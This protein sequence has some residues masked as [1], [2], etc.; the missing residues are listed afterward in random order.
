MIKITKNVP[1]LSNVDNPKNKNW[2]DHQASR[3]NRLVQEAQEHYKDLTFGDEWKVV[4]I[5]CKGLILVL[6]LAS[7]ASLLVCF[8]SLLSVRLSYP[9]AFGVSL[10]LCF[11]VEFLKGF[12]WGKLSKNVLKYKKYPLAIL[13]VSCF[14]VAVSVGGSIA[15]VDVLTSKASESAKG[16][17]L[18]PV[19][20]IDVKAMRASNAAQLAEL[21]KLIVDHAEQIKA[22]KSNTT[23]RSLSNG[24][25]QF[26]ASRLK[27]EEINAAAIKQA[28]EENDK[29][30]AE[31][32]AQIKEATKDQQQK[33]DTTNFYSRLLIILFELGLILANAFKSYYLFRVYVDTNTELSDGLTNTAD[34]N[35]S[36]TGP[37][38]GATLIQFPETPQQQKIG[39]IQGKSKKSVLENKT[40]N[41]S[42]FADKQDDEDISQV[43]S[44]GNNKTGD[45][46]GDVLSDYKTADG[47]NV[48]QGSKTREKTPLKPVKSKNGKRSKRCLHCGKKFQ[49]KNESKKYCS[50]KCRGQAFRARKTN[51]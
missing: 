16:L 22:T 3:D 17:Q 45:V 27:Q 21:D 36:N 9:V 32:A 34:A 11:F 25:R 7:F 19:P 12:V 40:G 5:A 2:S 28:T 10:I 30:L 18:E 43:I 13:S 26:Q 20:L 29:A 31:Q 4:L 37:S 49:Y 23:K 42:R 38:N 6:G 50:S 8:S 41:V 24:I 46:L 39:F 51:T 14:L 1:K 47:G 35:S 33:K 15:G 44:K 48:G